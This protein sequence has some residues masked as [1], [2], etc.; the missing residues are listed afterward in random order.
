MPREVPLVKYPSNK[1]NSYREKVISAWRAKD[2]WLSEEQFRVTSAALVLKQ[3]V[4]AADVAAI[5]AA[6]SFRNFVE[7]FVIFIM[8]QFPEACIMNAL[9]VLAL[10]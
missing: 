10:S 2:N 4:L 6:S 8:Q 7:I 9:I 3:K 5:L 1:V